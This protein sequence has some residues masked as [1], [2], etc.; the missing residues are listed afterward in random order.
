MEKLASGFGL[1]EG[2]VWDAGRGLIFSDVIFGGVYNLDSSGKVHSLFGH[3]RGIG[4]MALHESGGLIVSGRNIS[5]KPFDEGDTIL[6]LDRDEEQGKVG[7]NDLTTDSRGRV[8]AGSLGSS[9]VFED[10]R[11]PSAGDLYLIDLDGSSRLV[12]KDIM[13]TN[14][15][16]FSPDGK[17][18]YHSDTSRKVVNSYSVNDDGSLGDKTPFITT[19]TGLPDGLVVSEDGCVWVALAGGGKGVAV[20]TEDGALSQFI[21]IPLP[22]CTSVCF[23]GGDLRDLYIVTGSDGTNLEKGGAIFLYRTDVPGLPV[24][25]AKVSLTSV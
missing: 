15:L 2:P 17:T 25:K 22:M 11:E 20:Y 14:G 9:P 5:F 19:E 7:F 24:T 13:L 12:S 16:G 4:G 1:I 18:L 6:V 8:Y 21:E 10:G 3:R 23:G